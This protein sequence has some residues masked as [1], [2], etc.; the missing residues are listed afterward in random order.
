MQITAVTSRNRHCCLGCELGGFKEREQ[1]K[2]WSA[3]KG[4]QRVSKGPLKSWR[5]GQREGGESL[6]RIR[7]GI[8]TS[9]E[10]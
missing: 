8:S 6:I 9:E 4:I 5:R 10:R 7:P 2:I 1:G 3:K